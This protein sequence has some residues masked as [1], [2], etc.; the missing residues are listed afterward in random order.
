MNV[1]V[2]G[3]HILFGSEFI[4]PDWMEETFSGLGDWRL[5]VC[6]ERCCL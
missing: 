5:H 6:S 1:S 2:D 4:V 3:A